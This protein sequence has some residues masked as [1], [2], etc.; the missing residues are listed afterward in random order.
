MDTWRL[1]EKKQKKQR[2]IRLGE[3]LVESCSCNSA[4]YRRLPLT[5]LCMCQYSPSGTVDS[6]PSLLFRS[7]IPALPYQLPHK[8]TIPIIARKRWNCFGG[9]GF[10]SPSAAIHWVRRN[11]SKSTPRSMTS[12]TKWNFVSMCFV[13][14]WNSGFSVN[15]IAP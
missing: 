11:L 10:V 14:L 6:L 13:R 2:G 3:Y 5:S 1:K 15:A 12:W 8:Q 7:A 4:H 9:R